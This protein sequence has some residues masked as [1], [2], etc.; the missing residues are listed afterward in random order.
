MGTPEED[1]ADRLRQFGPGGYNKTLAR[2]I[3]LVENLGAC[4][5][6]RVTSESLEHDKAVLVLLEEK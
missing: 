1:A 3:W 2:D 5:S 4:P 6:G